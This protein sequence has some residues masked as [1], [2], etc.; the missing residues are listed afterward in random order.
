VPRCEG[1]TG[2]VRSRS[3]VLCYRRGTMRVWRGLE[4]EGNRSR[5]DGGRAGRCRSGGPRGG[6]A[7]ALIALVVVAIG[8][9]TP[10]PRADADAEG[11]AAR[12][13]AIYAFSCAACHGATGQ[14]FAEAVAAFPADY[15]HC[16]RCHQPTNA[17]QMPGSQVGLATMAF[18]LG[19]PPALAEP[20]RLARFG[21]GG[22][23][24][25]YLQATMPR[26]AP[27]SLGDDAYLDV[28]THLLRMVG[29]LGD[30][31]TLDLAGLEARRLE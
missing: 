24:L 14:G 4:A 17:P 9:G 3:D 11:Q 30:D 5:G 21:T 7:A 13:A 2:G 15:R 28:A 18:S 10:A 25:H 26:W 8:L 27:G 1:V 16:A 12:G 31:E 6:I 29:A 19:D 22:A 23:L 20:G